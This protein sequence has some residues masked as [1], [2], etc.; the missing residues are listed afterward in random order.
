MTQLQ[1][2]HKFVDYVAQTH[3]ALYRSSDDDWEINLGRSK[4]RMGIPTHLMKI[5]KSDK[6]YR[7]YFVERCPM[8]RG[9]AH[10][11]I[12]I[13]HEIGHHFNR[14]IFLF[15]TDMKEYEELRGFDHFNCPCER[16]ATE[17]AFEWLKDAE[18]RKVA[19]QFEREFFSH[20]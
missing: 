10:V 12:S 11:T 7:A 17:W 16:V 4:P 2:I 18:H 20:A 8:G 15:D 5:D 3:V 6:A 19:K 14:E 1:A 13:L 9:F